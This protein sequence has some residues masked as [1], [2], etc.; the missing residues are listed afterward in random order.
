LF[1]LY[2]EVKNIRDFFNFLY[3]DYF[4]PEKIKLNR[5]GEIWNQGG[6]VTSNSRW[7]KNIGYIL[8]PPQANES[9]GVTWYKNVLHKVAYLKSR[10]GS[11]KGPDSK[12]ELILI[13]T[14][15]YSVFYFYLFYFLC[16]SHGDFS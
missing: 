14:R 7:S 9:E 5:R 11:I 12:K 1:I 6:K 15:S 2:L 4:L 10:S 13:W 8:K 16:F 3:T